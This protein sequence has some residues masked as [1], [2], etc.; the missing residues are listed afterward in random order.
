MFS[1]QESRHY[2][3]LPH[4]EPWHVRPP[5]LGPQR[6]FVDTACEEATGT[7]GEEAGE[8]DATT[9]TTLDAGFD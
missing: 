1:I 2:I 6:A 7:A 4:L 3:Q 9:G 5:K 8:L